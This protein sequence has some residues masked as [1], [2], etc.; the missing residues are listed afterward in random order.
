VKARNVSDNLNL[1][2]CASLNAWL[3]NR[4]TN[5]HSV[6]VPMERGKMEFN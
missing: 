5:Y 1:V 4:E 2:S 6:R 3:Y